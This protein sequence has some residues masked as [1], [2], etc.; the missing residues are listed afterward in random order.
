[1]NAP[2]T[3]A[4]SHVVGRTDTPLLEETLGVLIDRAAQQHG[5]ADALVSA[6]QG[7][8]LSYRG[9][10]DEV[11]R[12]ARGL[13]ALGLRQGERIGIW[14]PNRAEW[15]LTQ[16]AS[17]RLGLVLVTLNPAYRELEVLHALRLSG[18]RAVV[19]PEAHKTSRYHEMLRALQAGRQ[20]GQRYQAAPFSVQARKTDV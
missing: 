12:V 6:S 4:P 2:P 14:S 13:L 1:M 20:G 19:A 3:P 10:R 7:V 9:L 8:R 18:C 17:A 15:V 16:L 11:D 5:D